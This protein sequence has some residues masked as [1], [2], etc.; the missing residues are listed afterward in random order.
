MPNRAI[1]LAGGGPAAGF[2][3]GVL[4]GLA[5]GAGD[6]H[7][8]F[9]SENDVWALS[10]IGAWVGIAYNQ[11]P[12]GREIEELTRF[13]FD[14][15][16]NDKS[17]QSFPANTVFSADWAGNAE[18][19]LDFMLDPANYRNAFLPREIMKSFVHTVSALRRMSVPSWRRRTRGGR[20]TYELD[21]GGFSEG[22][23]NRWT[24]NH[25]L[26]VHPVTRFLTAMIYKS[27][28]DGL[29]RLYYEDSSF[30]KQLDFDAVRAR[31]PFIYYN[32]WN[33]TRQMLVLFANRDKQVHSTTSGHG[34]EIDGY[35][36]VNAA[37]LC[38]CSALPYVLQTVALDGDIY[39]EGALIDTV[40]FSNLLI[41]HPHLDEIWV[42]R[43]VDANQV[44]P[45]RN[46]YDS[47]ANLCEL[48]CATVGEDD[49]E[50]FKYE[51]QFGKHKDAWSKV[52]LVEIPVESTINFEWSHSNL[53]HGIECG[54][55][56]AKRAVDAYLEQ[57]D[58][59]QIIRPEETKEQKQERLHNR[60]EL[61]RKR[62]MSAGRAGSSR[63]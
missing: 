62:V 28:M 54:E 10:C 3:I 4:K 23:F 11:A 53:Q 39:C 58:T 6:R 34:Y 30:L 50:L 32:A 55:R 49:V 37:S 47:L 44:L 22:D 40:N 41:D 19:M 25:V 17:F 15:F 43:I 1:C 8:T 38:A 59:R 46:V 63:P 31:K 14:V 56:A 48:F 16:R 7:I 42:S 29:A 52:K 36:P 5:A 57:K 45:P 35:R 24:L 12:Q 20:G 21:F 33:L 18:A 9:D 27:N 13:F 51:L 2:H 61:A 60:R 26:A